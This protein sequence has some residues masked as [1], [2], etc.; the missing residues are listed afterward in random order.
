MEGVRFVARNMQLARCWVV[1][2]RCSALK[3]SKKTLNGVL[4]GIIFTQIPLWILAGRILTTTRARLNQTGTG[5]WLKLRPCTPKRGIRPVGQES[6]LIS[7]KYGRL[8]GKQ[9]CRH[10]VQGSMGMSG[11]SRAVLLRTHDTQYRPYQKCV[12]ACHRPL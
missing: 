1:G 10:F 9:L 6:S 3:K 5:C 12:R 11:L 7:D 8:R 4:V 2:A